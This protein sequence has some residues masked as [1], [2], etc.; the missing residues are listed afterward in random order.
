VP[1]THTNAKGK[2]YY[3]LLTGSISSTVHWQ[4][5]SNAMSN[6]SRKRRILNCFDVDRAHTPMDGDSERTFRWTAGSNCS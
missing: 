3:L 4:H 1:I 2:T 6:T 5:W